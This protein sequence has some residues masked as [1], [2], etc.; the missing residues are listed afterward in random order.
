MNAK[1][2]RLNFLGL[3]PTGDIGHVTMY[4]NAAKRTVAFTKSPPL[5]PASALQ[6]RQRARFTLAAQSWQNLPK[7]RRENWLLAA[8]R[9]RLHLSGYGLWTWFSIKRNPAPIRTI[10]RQ[11]NLSLLNT[12][13]PIE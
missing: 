9:A 13:D 3:R 12:E 11:T 2:R 5:E 1:D 7:K 4:T 8:R 6:R 10:E